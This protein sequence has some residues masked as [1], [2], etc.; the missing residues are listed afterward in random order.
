MAKD[1]NNTATPEAVTERTFWLNQDQIDELVKGAKSKGLSLDKAIEMI[2]SQG[3]QIGD[4][5]VY[6][7]QFV[8]TWHNFETDKAVKSFF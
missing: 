4:R 2:S 8:A 6:M 3:Y 5:Q 7:T 1:N